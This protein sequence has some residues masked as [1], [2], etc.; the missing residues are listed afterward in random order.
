MQGSGTPPQGRRAPG[1]A[2]AAPTAAAAA[3]FRLLNVYGATNRHERWFTNLRVATTCSESLLACN[4]TFLA[5][6]WAAHGG[7]GRLYVVPLEKE[8]LKVPDTPPLVL[9]HR[10]PIVDTCLSAVDEALVATSSRDCN[11]KVWRLPAPGG[12]SESLSRS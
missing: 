3:D 10:H 2:A 4:A 1:T 8:G 6:P 11:V 7:D 5:V 9:A 12:L